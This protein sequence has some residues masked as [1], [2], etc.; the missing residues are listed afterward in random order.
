M[1]F[2]RASYNFLSGNVK[3]MKYIH[4]FFTIK[5]EEKPSLHLGG[6]NIILQ[7]L[8]DLVVGNQIKE[9]SL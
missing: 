1:E 3:N 9:K 2:R 7:V 4:K 8:C 6:E 5:K